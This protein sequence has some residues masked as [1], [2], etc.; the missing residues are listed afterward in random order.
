MNNRF[1]QWL[2]YVLL[3]NSAFVHSIGVIV[4]RPS[5]TLLGLISEHRNAFGLR[6]IHEG[7]E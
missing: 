6:V 3:D 2:S 7:R 5:A 1:N 4:H